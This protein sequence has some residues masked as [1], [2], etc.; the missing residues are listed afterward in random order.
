[1]RKR[2]KEGL[3]HGGWKETRRCLPGTRLRYIED[4]L[5]WSVDTTS[6]SMC[7]LTGVAGS[8]KSAIVHEIAAR[9]HHA[10]RMYS[11]FFFQRDD[12][13]I[14]PSVIQLLA[15]GLSSCSDSLRTSV[16]EAMELLQ[17]GRAVPSL[18]QQ[19]ESFL[20]GPLRAF[21]TT[22]KSTPITFILDA[23]DECPS[24]IRTELMEAL[25]YGIPLLPPNVKL[26]ATSRPQADI[27]V[28]LKKVSPKTIHLS[29]RLTHEDGDLKHFF[30]HELTEI[31]TV[32]NLDGSWSHKQ[33]MHDVV[34][35]SNQACGLFQWAAVACGL[36]WR[37]FNPRSA[38]DRILTL[39]SSK[40]PQVNLDTL[41]TDCL[42]QVFP[43]AKNDPELRDTYVQV[44]GTIIAAKE[45]LEIPALHDLLDVDAA[46]ID[47]LLL[48]LGCVISMESVLGTRVAQIA[49]PSFFEFVTDASRCTDNA[50]NLHKAAV[51]RELGSRCFT[52]AFASLKR[53]ICQVADEETDNNEMPPE[54]LVSCLTPVLRYSC[55]F[56]LVHAS[57][58]V[59]SDACSLSDRLDDFLRRKLLEW[60]E[61]M[62]LLQLLDTAVLMLREFPSTN[63]RSVRTLLLTSC[64]SPCDSSCTVRIVSSHRNVARRRPIYTS[65]RSGNHEECPP[66]LLVRTTFYA[67]GDPSLSQLQGQVRRHSGQGGVGS[68]MASRDLH[69]RLARG[70]EVSMSM[71]ARCL[72]SKLPC[73]IFS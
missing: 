57:E 62:S 58:D 66:D 68:A 45:P 60:I 27:A 9:H 12:A 2:I 6:P 10:Q 54:A 59:A 67:S 36:I 26:F 15:Y 65:L 51:S 14:A 73:T 7:W 20:V 17:D 64:P 32:K 25:R 18:S 35:L 29:V 49:H 40:D 63:G 52:Q 34:A 46:T 47:R 50:F 21:Y 43:D 30:N 8:G 53:N 22:H 48:E 69:A 42:H 11:C 71:P 13:N 61:V 24:S 1:V 28:Y 55:Q 23:L 70:H 44:V 38:I 5:R 37:R 41:Y 16:S 4:I 72:S 56:L 3:D 39:R 33:L 19:F 31:R